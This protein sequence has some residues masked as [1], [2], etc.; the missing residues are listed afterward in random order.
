MSVDWTKPIEAVEKATGRVVPMEF[1]QKDDANFDPPLYLTKDSPAGSSNI[2]WKVDGRDNCS[3]EEWFIRNTVAPTPAI[4]WTK[5]LELEDGTPVVIEN[6]PL[7]DD[8]AFAQ[9]YALQRA[10]G[11]RF[12]PEQAAGYQV[13][14]WEL[15]GQRYRHFSGTRADGIRVRNV[16]PAAAQHSI[17][18][19]TITITDLPVPQGFAEVMKHTVVGADI[20]GILISAPDK[21]SIITP[22]GTYEFRITSAQ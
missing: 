12:T 20:T 8:H 3:R 15:D 18:S 22:N 1:W 9:Y 2:Y 6:G 16:E 10:D 11:E 5:P 14:C 7:G 4:D 21:M 17:P 19:A 13:A